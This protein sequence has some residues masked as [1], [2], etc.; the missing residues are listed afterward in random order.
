MLNGFLFVFCAHNRHEKNN[1]SLRL[2]KG[3]NAKRWVWFAS[4]STCQNCWYRI[5]IKAIDDE[6]NYQV[7][8]ISH[9]TEWQSFI[10]SLIPMLAHWLFSSS[11]LAHT[12][13]ACHWCMS[14]AE[15]KTINKW[16][17]KSR[18]YYSIVRSKLTDRN[19]NNVRS[20]YAITRFVIPLCVWGPFSVWFN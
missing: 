9:K 2:M 4:Q 8:V 7:H 13:H 18:R 11:L 14:I 19:S 15:K 17:E 16:K 6:K 3:T 10:H 12:Q 5:A 20:T 1:K